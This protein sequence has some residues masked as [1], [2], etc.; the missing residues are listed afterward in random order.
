MSGR[1]L[2]LIVPDLDGK[3]SV[4]GVRTSRCAKSEGNDQPY[5]ATV[6][7][8][9]LLERTPEM[10]GEARDDSTEAIEQPLLA[11]LTDEDRR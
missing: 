5:S 7:S 1:S 3:E 11:H 6:K 4:C 8:D 9:G 10:E 2:I